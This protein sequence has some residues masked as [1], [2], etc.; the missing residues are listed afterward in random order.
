MFQQSLGKVSRLSLKRKVPDGNGLKNCSNYHETVQIRSG[1]LRE[2]TAYESKINLICIN[3]PTSLNLAFF[4]S[5]FFQKM[6]F[7]RYILLN[8]RL[9][10]FLIILKFLLKKTDFCSYKTLLLKIKSV[11]CITKCTY[12]YNQCEISTLFSSHRA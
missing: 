7:C 3:W 1:N 9:H 8:R 2:V 10:L 11:N 12:C 4:L 5:N 6:R